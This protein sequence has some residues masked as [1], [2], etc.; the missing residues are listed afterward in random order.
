M[1]IVIIKYNIVHTGAN[2]QSGGLNTGLI[3]N[4]YQGSLKFIVAKPPISDAE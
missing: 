2:I 4:E 3:N 1:A